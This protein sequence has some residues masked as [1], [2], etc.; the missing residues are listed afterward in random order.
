MLRRLWGVTMLKELRN[1]VIILTPVVILAVYIGE[2]I[3]ETTAS[4]IV[5]AII[6][7]FLL[8]AGAVAASIW[9]GRRQRGRYY[10]EAPRR[11]NPPQVTDA[12]WR[13]FNPPA[14]PPANSQPAA[15]LPAPPVPRR[16]IAPPQEK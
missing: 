10:Q 15:Q 6:G 1:I 9:A 3:N 8:I 14:N 12:Q 11:P 16:M 5:G 2:Q 13:Y 4:V 7:G